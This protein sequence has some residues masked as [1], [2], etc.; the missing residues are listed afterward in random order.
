MFWR[1]TGKKSFSPLFQANA[2]HVHNNLMKI[3]FNIEIE[4]DVF[5]CNMTPK[6]KKVFIDLRN[7]SINKWCSFSGLRPFLIPPA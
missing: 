3:N 7:N 1:G 6:D 2:I 5:N 4:H